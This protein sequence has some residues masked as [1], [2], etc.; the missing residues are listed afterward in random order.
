MFSYYLPYYNYDYKFHFNIIIIIFPFIFYRPLV[1]S[2]SI[3]TIRQWY[4]DSS[5]L[6]ESTLS[7]KN[8]STFIFR[9][10]YHYQGNHRTLIKMIHRVSYGKKNEKSVANSGQD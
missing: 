9:L 4:F 2:K 5:K 10:T 8:P 6:K 3:N 1:Q 7:P